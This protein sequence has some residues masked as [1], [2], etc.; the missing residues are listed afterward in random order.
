MQHLAELGK[1]H[2]SAEPVRVLADLLGTTETKEH[3]QLLALTKAKGVT[4]TEAVMP[5]KLQDRL[6]A[7]PKDAFDQTWL[8]E[9]SG[10]IKTS[11]QNYSAGSTSTDKDIK[12]FAE[13]GLALAQQKLDVVKKVASR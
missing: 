9:V 2:A 11:I 4:L 5:K 10:L 13:D 7:A 12:K 3:S 1:T 6:S 8:E